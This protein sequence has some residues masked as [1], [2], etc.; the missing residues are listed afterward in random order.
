MKITEAELNAKIA[1]RRGWKQSDKL[2]GPGNIRVWLHSDGDE[3]LEAPAYSSDMNLA[4]ELLGVMPHHS[5]TKRKNERGGK[6][7]LK[8]NQKFDFGW[9]KLMIE[10]ESP[11]MAICLAWLQLKTNTVYEVIE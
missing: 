8:W 10:H 6:W 5:F 9:K 7:L 4:I 11:S 2:V 3:L 1:E